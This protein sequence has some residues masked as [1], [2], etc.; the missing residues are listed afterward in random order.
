MFN[1]EEKEKY[2]GYKEAQATLPNN[3]L[4]R[5][6]K[7][8]EDIEYDLSID[9]SDW[10]E[11]IIIEFYKRKNS[12][13]LHSLEVMNGRLAE[14][15]DFLNRAKGNHS[16][17]RFNNITIDVLKT[18]IDEE[19]SKKRF[20]TRND[21]YL[22]LNLLDNA[23]DKFVLTA[24]FEGIKG[25]GFEQIWRLQLKDISQDQV[26][27]CNGKTIDL[28]DSKL[29][30]YAHESAESEFYYTYGKTDAAVRMIGSPD[31]IIKATT[32]RQNLEISDDPVMIARQDK[33]IFRK[34]E[35]AANEIGWMEVKPRS[36]LISGQIEYALRLSK[37]YEIDIDKLIE[38]NEL[39]KR[40]CNRFINI[41]SKNEFLETARYI[42][43][44]TISSG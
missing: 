14:Y 18:C 2:I 7:D 41:A 35:R 38:T 13:S 40:L 39:F 36:I 8:T 30:Y 44:Q 9:V 25:K 11:P 43:D 1:A 4:N 28:M 27:L 12:S 42:Q 33:N 5:L 32:I 16:V 22:S 19:K 31:Q 21:F 26:V 20:L 37:K 3:Y 17:N 29:Y 24:L 10:D 6:F 15:T 34:F 23:V